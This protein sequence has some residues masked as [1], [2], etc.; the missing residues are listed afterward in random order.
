MPKSTQRKTDKIRYAVVGLGWIAQEAILPAFQNTT[1]AELTALVT[2]DPEK[3]SR[4]GR[5]YNVSRTA[6]YDEYDDLLRSG[7]VEAVYIA[8]PNNQHRDFTIRAARAGVH[9]LCEKPMADTVEECQEMI[10]ACEE[11]DVKLMIAYRL[12]FESA[13]LQAIDI[14]EQNAIG[15]PKIFSSVFSQQVASGDIRLKKD[16]GGGPLM[17]MGVYPINAARYLFRDEPIEVIATAANS[18]DSRFREVHET[19]TAILRFPKDRLATL[20]CSFGVAAADSYEVV[21]TKGDLWMKPAYDYHENLQL[22]VKV[23][24]DEK[25]STIPIHDQFA[26]ELEYF[27]NCIR[28]DEEPEP[29]GREGLADIRIVQAVNASI[30]SGRPIKLDPFEKKTRPSLNQKFEKPRIK[31]PAAVHASAPTG[32]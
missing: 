10:R 16:L 9:V 6:T 20:T 17:D 19:V 1:E 26:P 8:L 24:G 32:T 13:N 14:I 7:I 25:V 21:G 28:N 3:A 31:P 30:S 23:D 11:A 5:Q 4:L 18:G 27:A 12:H 22:R 2:D 15:E 29:S